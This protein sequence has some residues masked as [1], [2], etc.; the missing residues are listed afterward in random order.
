[1]H[2]TYSDYILQ[3]NHVLDNLSRLKELGASSVEMLMDGTCWDDADSTWDHLAPQLAQCGLRLTI[4]PPSCDTNLT[5][6]MET[7]RDASFSL[8]ERAIYLAQQVGAESVVIHPGF[9]YSYRFDK[10]RAKAHAKE[11][12][13]LLSKVAKER[14]IRLLV[15]N[16]G[17][18]Y[19][20][21]YTQEEYSHLLDDVDPIAGYLIDTGHAHIN[22]WCIPQLICATAPRLYGFHIHD[23]DGSC[24]AHLSLGNGTIDWSPIFDAMKLL[25]DDCDYILEY[26]PRVKL[27][28][29]VRDC[30]ALQQALRK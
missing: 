20:S 29:L 13:Q 24:D 2:F 15:E 17:F 12:I 23:N 1:M 6:E 21:L 26:S 22:H 25:H 10:N 5:A 14:N 8:Y 27:E 16:V 4:H 18:G 19:A 30:N 9:T 11:A 7:L 28:E 3:G